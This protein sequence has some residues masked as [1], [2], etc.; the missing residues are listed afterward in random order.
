MKK[1]KSQKIFFYHHIIDHE[2]IETYTY[3][4]RVKL[5]MSDQP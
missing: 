4:F 3:T 1:I 2:D 5:K